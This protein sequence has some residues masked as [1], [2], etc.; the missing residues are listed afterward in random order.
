MNTV[1]AVLVLCLRQTVP[2]EMETSVV[3][4]VEWREDARARGNDRRGGFGCVEEEGM[5]R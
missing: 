1:K 4:E 3:R 5:E 2:I